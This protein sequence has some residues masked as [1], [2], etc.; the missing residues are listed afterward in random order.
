MAC[1]ML[2]KMRNAYIIVVKQR[3][4]VGDLG[5]GRRRIILKRTL[6]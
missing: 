5:V 4:L 6:V 3:N 2:R 1:D